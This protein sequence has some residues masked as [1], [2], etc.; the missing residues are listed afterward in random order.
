MLLTIGMIV[1][2][3][4]KYLRKCLTAL[5]PILKNVSSE[6][7]IVDTGSTDRTVEIAKEFTD[8]VL[9]FEWIKDFA[10]ARNFGMKHAKGEW[11][12][13]VDADEIFLSCDDIIS[14]FNTGEYK[15]FNSASFSVRSYPEPENRHFYTDFYVPRM[16]K[17]LPETKY[18][19]PVHEKLTTYAHPIRILTDVADHYGYSFAN[20][21]E[22]MKQKYTRNMELLKERL[23]TDEKENNPSLYKE[24]IDTFCM[25]DF[26]IIKENKELLVGYARKAIEICEKQGNDYILGMYHTLMTIYM[27]LDCFEDAV[28]LHDEYFEV[29]NKIRR[30][31]RSNDIDIIG[32]TANA[33]FALER[34]E[35]AC[36]K[37][38][39]FFKLYAAMQNSRLCTNDALYSIRYLTSGRSF[40]SLCE[41]YTS[42]CLNTGRYKEAEANLSKY[43]LKAFKY[44]KELYATRMRQQTFLLT[45]YGTKEILRIYSGND[46]KLKKELFGALRFVIINLGEAERRTIINKLSSLNLK[47]A[48]YRALISLYKAHFTGGGAGAERID[49]FI[50][51]HGAEYTDVL[52]IM[53]AE[54]LD[55][56]SFVNVCTNADEIA[57]VGYSCINDFGAKLEGYSIENINNAGIHGAAKLYLAAVIEGIKCGRAM[58]GMLNTLGN[59]GIRY[60]QV[61]GE[62]NIPAEVYAAVTIGEINLLRSCRD[63]KGCIGAVRRLIKLDKRYAPVGAL[64]QK[65]IK[66]DMDSLLK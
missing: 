52:Y 51:K 47:N 54:G 61:F 18:V 43:P 31:V 3:E 16:T 42:C 56:T 25:Q 7:I 20:D 36:E 40:D 4:E 27:K 59:I 17:L 57:G 26:S 5:Q 44:D 9:Y 30:G 46:E 15:D 55:I 32:F 6:L 35:E 34:Y 37:Y 8:K 14:F 49:T 1:K 13:A 10:A 21:P 33:L 11:F 66:S 22:L 29:D 60:L 41:N 19:N 65:L 64:Y 63:F 23:E 58:D 45:K 12:M 2:N 48:A 38:E 50:Q 53:L 62:S 39:N 28:K 24:L